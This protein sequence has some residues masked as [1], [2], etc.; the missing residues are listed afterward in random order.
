MKT[1]ADF[2]KFL[3][4]YLSP[5]PDALLWVL[6]YTT[7]VHAV[8]DIIDEEIRDEEFLLKT[9]EMAAVVYSSHFYVRNISALYPLIVMASNTYMDSV[10]LEKQSEAWKRYTADH[11]RQTGNEVILACI[12]IVGGMDVRRQASMEL[13]EI[14]YFLHHD[15][16]GRPC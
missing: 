9:F 4:K 12:Q 13:R 16:E 11:L 6:S 3:E 14:S 7:Y 5:D 8:D 2:V 10:I 15:S 1:K